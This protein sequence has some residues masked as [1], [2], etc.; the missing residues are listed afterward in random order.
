MK[1]FVFRHKM[2]LKFLYMRKF[3]DL[4]KKDAAILIISKLG[5]CM[6]ENYHDICKRNN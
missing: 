1:S 2:P 6:F 3:L 4:A 5:Y